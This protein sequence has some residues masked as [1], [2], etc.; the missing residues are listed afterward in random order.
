MDCIP[1]CF[2]CGCDKSLKPEGN[3]QA[4]VCPRC[5]NASVTATKESN[6]FTFCWVP[7]VPLGS[8]HVWYCSICQWTASQKGPAPPLAQHGGFHGA[9]GMPMGGYG[10]GGYGGGPPPQSGMMYPQ[11]PMQPGYQPGYR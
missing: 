1:L 8:E 9:Q 5:N 7:I 4:H 6:C 3:G 2:V 11:Q 10:G